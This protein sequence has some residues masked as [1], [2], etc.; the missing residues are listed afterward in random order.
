[1]RAAPDMR[2]LALTCGNF[3]LGTASMCMVGLLNEVSADLDLPVAKAGQLASASYIVA[4]L[5]APVI[6]FFTGRMQRRTVLL[7]ALATS[8]AAQLA[9][10]LAVGFW[11][12]FAARLLF[13]AGVAAHAP[14]AAATSSL[15]AKPE[16]RGSAVSLVMAGFALAGVIGV[17]LGVWFG[18]LFGWRATMYATTGLILATLLGVAV[19]IPSRLPRASLSR[20]AWGQTL[21]N[22]AVRATLAITLVMSIG[23]MS[24]FAYIAPLLRQALDA[25]PNTIAALM[26][27][28]GLS[29]I[30]GSLAGMR[31]MDSVRPQRMIRFSAVLVMLAMLLWPFVHGSVAGCVVV[32]I[33]W[34]A[35]SMTLYSAVSA[36]ILMVS[37]E[38][39]SVAMA[40]NTSVNFFGNVLGTALG[41]MLVS[42]IGLSAL[43]WA[44]FASYGCVLLVLPAIGRRVQGA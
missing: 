33:L 12:L 9:S 4:A 10:A 19:T 36:Q 13:G 21:R 32:I 44:C 8:V 23:Q 6:A 37:H 31:F 22:G 16:E 38:L 29:S 15:L 34:G 7:L 1:M 41:G 40:I 43:S 20:G 5:L 11:S 3:A 2:L 17:P 30:A 27:V 14:T 28:L 26:G 42:G 24:A 39:A 25:G 18:G 35:G